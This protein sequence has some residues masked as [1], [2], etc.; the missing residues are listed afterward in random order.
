MDDVKKRIL[1]VDDEPAILAG[2]RD[3]FR[4]DRARWEMV[5]ALGGQRALDEFRKERFDV[6]VSD[7]RMPGVDGATLLQAVN[8]Q[9]PTTVR[10][11][12]TGYADDDALARVR[13]V[14]HQLLSKPCSAASLRDAIERN[15]DSELGELGELRARSHDDDRNGSE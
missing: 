1:F 11:M 2:L 6:V 3:M 4:K 7:M 8:D 15:I 13:P 5:F 9:S 10:I 14:L 12:L